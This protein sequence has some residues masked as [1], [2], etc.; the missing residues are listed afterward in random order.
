MV[1]IV[2]VIGYS[3]EQWGLVADQLGSPA[4][5]KAINLAL[6][7]QLLANAPDEIIAERMY[8]VFSTFATYGAMSQQT[9]E[10]LEATVELWFAEVEGEG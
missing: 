8:Q 2:D 3:A 9:V 7:E 4:V 6:S 10:L 5:A 1:E